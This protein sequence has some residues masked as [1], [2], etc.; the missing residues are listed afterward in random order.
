MKIKKLLN[1]QN[2]LLKFKIIKSKIY[3]KHHYINNIKIE[4]IEHRLKKSFH[5]IFKYHV[6]KKRILFIGTPNLINKDIQKF[7]KKTNHI[8]IPEAAWV[9]G[10]I[11]NKISFFKL[12]IKDKKFTNKKISEILFF[13]KKNIDLVVLLN[14]SNNTDNVL[15]ESYLTK[16]PVIS[17]NSSLNILNTK[18]SYE[19]PGDFKFSNKKIRDNFFYSILISTF[20]KGNLPKNKINLSLLS[21]N[22]S[23]KKHSLLRQRKINLKYVKN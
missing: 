1:S 3:N 4:D 18:S 5:I 19:I 12:F 13:L 15:D 8:L 16:I 11:S 21:F 2:K 22:K 10:L 17:F 7:F 9:N 14:E 6:L 23:I 20:K